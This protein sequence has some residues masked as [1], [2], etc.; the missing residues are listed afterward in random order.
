MKIGILGGSFDPVHNGHIEMA[1][2]CKEKFNLDKIMLL[3][4]GDPPHKNNI[5]QKEIR[6]KMLEASIKDISDFYISRL[7]IDRPGKTYT[8]DTIKWL[9]ENTDDQYFYII[10]GDTVS[11]L[12]KWYNAQNLFKI[13]EFIVVDRTDFDNKERSIAEILGAKLYLTHHSGLDVSSTEIRNRVKNGEDIKTLVSPNVEEIIKEY[14][15][16]KD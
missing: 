15:L 16:Y 3:P 10:G 9:K 5:T 8:F 12:H 11:T 4:L 1:V 14:G 7:E 2:F 13:L 6:L